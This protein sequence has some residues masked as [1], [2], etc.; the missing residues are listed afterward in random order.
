MCHRMWHGSST[1]FVVLHPPPV[2]LVLARVLFNRSF[3]CTVQPIF[4]FAPP[5]LT[6]LPHAG[7]R[8]PSF[9][10]TPGGDRGV[11]PR[12]PVARRV[13][14]AARDCNVPLIVRGP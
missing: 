2:R 3:A 1:L 5:S 12:A 7:P 4:W 14:A 6:S 13:P 11:Q 10:V 8:R 9:E